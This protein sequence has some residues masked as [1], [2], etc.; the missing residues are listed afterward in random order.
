MGRPEL[1]RRRRARLVRGVAGIP[2]DG[3]PHGRPTLTPARTLSHTLVASDKLVYSAHFYDYTGPNHSGATGVGETSDPRYRDLSRA[4]LLDVL[5]RDAFFAEDGGR[6]FTAP[7][8]ISEFGIDGSSPAGSRQ[9]D[10]FVNFADYLIRQDADFA[11]WPVVGWGETRA[12][13]DW[14][15]LFRDRAGNRSTAEGWKAEVW[16]RLR[17][18]GAARAGRSGSTAA[19]TARPATRAATSPPA[20]TRANATQAS[21]PPASPT[22]DGSAGHALLTPS[23]AGSGADRRVRPGGAHARKSGDGGA[24]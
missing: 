8:W 1:G 11:Y 24:G 21:T 20:P 23:T 2:V 4:E 12:G 10:W 6:H 15:L 9:R 22:P 5:H 18:G 19:T 3:L 7:V 13:N 14:A 17:R 16:S